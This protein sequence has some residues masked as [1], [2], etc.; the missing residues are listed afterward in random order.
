MDISNKAH[1]LE[2]FQDYNETKQ[3]YDQIKSALKMVKQTGYGV[4]SPTLFDMK[5]NTPEIIK[6][7]SRYGEIG[8]ASCRERV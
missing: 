4:A 6:Q 1:L 2:I 7:G 5:L 3:E 8:R